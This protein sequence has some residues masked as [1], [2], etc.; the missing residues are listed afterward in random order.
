MKIHSKAE[1]QDALNA[2]LSW[3]KREL[4]SVLNNVNTS[5]AKTQQY[6]LRSGILLLYA[7]WEGFIKNSCEAYL[8]FVKFQK[9]RL[10][11]LEDSFLA[12]AL[13]QKLAEFENTKKSTIH[14]QFIKFIRTNLNQDSKINDDIV[15]STMSNLNSKVLE[16]ILVTLGIDYSPFELKQNLIDSQLLNY[17]NNIA[18]GEYLI[19][20]LPEYKIIHDEVLRMINQIK[21]E[22]ENS[23][24]LEKYKISNGMPATGPV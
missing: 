13:K 9:L 7:H 1:L 4:T 24:F 8:N 10:N 16:Q 15:I 6:F 22:I 23:V 5:S 11:Q 17:R 19:M 21:T 20:D 14:A 3:R 2:D 18:H 12:I